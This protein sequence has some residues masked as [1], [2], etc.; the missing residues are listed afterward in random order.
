MKRP[1]LVLIHGF[2]GAPFGL[3]AIADELR[4]AG[5]D[6]HLAPN[7]PF[8]GAPTLSAYTPET[9]ADHFA[10]YLKSHH[11]IKPI[12][13]GH[14]MGT[15]TVSALAS[16]RPDLVDSRLILLS[17]ISYKTAKFFALLAPLSAYLPDFL[18]NFATTCYL[19]TGK[20]QFN[21]TMR[22][23]NACTKQTT[24]PKRAVFSAAYF[25]SHYGVADFQ[26]AD[27]TNVYIIAGTKDRL[28]SCR[29]TEKLAHSLHTKPVFLQDTGHL[30]NYEK[31]HETAEE[32]L[33][34]LADS[35]SAE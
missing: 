11:I 22:V 10:N 32:I 19:Y 35:S 6:V 29:S 9:Y 16:L 3:S 8:A 27:N 26:F 34:I 24:C 7:P 18:V 21:S 12:L 14:S 13:I 33:K 5:Y 1:P 28:I 17:P 2:R 25:S 20:G 31:P 23:T 30:H 15:L 4:I